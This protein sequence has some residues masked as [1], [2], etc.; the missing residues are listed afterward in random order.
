MNR[1][2]VGFISLGGSNFDT[3]C[4]KLILAESIRKIKTIDNVEIIPIEKL[5]TNLEEVNE[6]IVKFK[7]VNVDVLVVQNGTFAWG[8]LI[9]NIAQ[10]FNVPILLWAVPEPSF[11][12]GKPKLNSLCGVNLNSSILTKMGREIKFIYAESTEEEFLKSM[13][14]FLRVVETINLLKK[15]RVGLVGYRVPGFYNVVFDELALRKVFGIEIHHIDIAE[16]FARAEKVSNKEINLTIKEII[17]NYD[18]ITG[19]PKV[20]LE[21][22]AKLYLIFRE[23]IEEYALNGLAVKCWPEFISL[24]GLAACSTLSKLTN[25]GFPTSC[26]A[27]V[28]GAATMLIQKYLTGKPPFFADLI[29]IDKAENTALLWH[30]GSAP[31]SLAADDAKIILSEGIARGTGLNSRFPLKEG[32]VTIARLGNIR[33]KY[34]MFITQGKAIKT[35]TNLDGNSQ[36]VKLESKVEDV[37]NTIIYGGFEHHFSVIYQ[38]IQ[39]EL[40]ELCKLLKIEVVIV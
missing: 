24:Y 39:E 7:S 8:G 36:E 38:D 11:E 30:C 28:E 4:A 9:V 29:S 33:N 31:F 26:E 22:F 1:L 25:G 18:D 14:R 5:V 6:A 27:D 17:E 15:T 40:I 13:S 2:K 3:E 34:R 20:K 35:E 16:V 19:I 37:L 10:E 23:I 32:A 12:G 21:K